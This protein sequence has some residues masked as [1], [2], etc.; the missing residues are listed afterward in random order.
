MAIFRQLPSDATSVDVFCRIADNCRGMRMLRCGLLVVLCA[1]PLVGDDAPKVG[2]IDCLSRD[3]PVPTPVYSDPCIPKPVES[4]SCGEKVEVLGR[5]GPWL[6]IKSTDGGERYIGVT[7]VSQNKNRF[8][9]LDFPIPSESYTRD[10][11]AFRPKTGKVRAQPIY[12]PQPEYTEEARRTG[13]QGTVTLAITIGTDGHV[14]EVKV[15]N[16]LGHGLDEKAV[17]AVQSWKFAPA[18]E[19]GTPVES[20]M[21]VEI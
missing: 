1:I 3:K 18:L 19:E 10:C 4:L 9:P 2:Y 8:V 21:A 20:K 17:E 16:G 15:L 7:S 14:H 12:N 13:V 6:K 5:K 11:S